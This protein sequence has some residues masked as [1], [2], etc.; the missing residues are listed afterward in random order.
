M[1]EYSTLILSVEAPVARLT[2]NRPDR[3]NTMSRTMVREVKAALQTVAE[4]SD[5]RVLVLTGAGSM[6]CPGADM[7]AVAAG[8][9]LGDR[10]EPDDFL[11]TTLLHHMPQVTVA[12]ING[13]CAGAGLG[14]AAA[15]DLRLA[16]RRAKF[17][18][19]FLDV[20]VAGDMGLPWS[21]PRLIGAGRARELCMM[22]GKFDA[23]EALRLGLVARVFDDAVFAEEVEAVIARLAAAAPFALTTMKSNFVEAER[24]DFDSFILLESERHLHLFTLPDTQE[25]FAAR[26]EGRAAQFSAT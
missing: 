8:D 13:A 6:F 22:P 23:D 12:A 26:V 20:A 19:A 4:R 24:R 17:N 2:L 5:V 7:K 10:L 21:L 11:V 3:L 9:E 16:T 15:C 18:T 1:A 25:G 14:W